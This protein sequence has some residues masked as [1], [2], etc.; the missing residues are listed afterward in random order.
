MLQR[1]E[2]LLLRSKIKV[3]DTAKKIPSSILIEH[4]VGQRM[5]GTVSK[6]L[7]F[8]AYIALEGWKE[9]WLHTSELE[10]K[11]TAIVEDGFKEENSVN[12][13]ITGAGRNGRLGVSR[14]ACVSE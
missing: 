13:A 4:E 10:G 14:K 9:S 3:I 11:R 12:V 5:T 8:G 1:M 2:T 6:V 7:P